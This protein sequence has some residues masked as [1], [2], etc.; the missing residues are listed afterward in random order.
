MIHMNISLK[1]LILPPSCFHKLPNYYNKTSLKIKINQEINYIH[2]IGLDHLKKLKLMSQKKKKK[3]NFLQLQ[4]QN[5]LLGIN[6]DL[7]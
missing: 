7:I 3:T 1:F 4:Q 2:P 5:D 6:L